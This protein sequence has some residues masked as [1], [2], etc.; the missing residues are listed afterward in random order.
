MGSEQCN[1]TDAQGR[2]TLAN[3]EGG[4]YGLFSNSTAEY[5]HVNG[6]EAVVVAG[7]TVTGP[8]LHVEAGGRLSGTVVDAAGQLMTLATVCFE[9]DQLQGGSFACTSTTANGSWRSYA[10]P[11]G[12][13]KVWVGQGNYWND[14]NARVP[15][16][17][18]QPVTVTV[19]AEV[20]GLNITVPDAGLMAS[21]AEADI[22]PSAELPWMDPTVANDPRLLPTTPQS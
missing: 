11:A 19:G 10:L 14:A 17:D 8:D 18:G 12:E 22:A 21:A 6:G 16:N 4:T 2:Y 5:Y 7:Q 1:L 13:Y 3:L 9:G 20:S 15:Y